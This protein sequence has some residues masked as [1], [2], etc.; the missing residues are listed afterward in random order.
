VRPY[1]V[2]VAGGTGSGKTTVARRIAEAAPTEL[3]RT[4]EHDAYYRDR[5]DLS[6]DERCALNFDHPESLETSLMVQHLATLRRGEAVDVPVYDYAS[7][8]RAD[9]VRRV[10]PAPVIVDEGIL[11]FENAD[12]RAALDLKLF[13][14][15]DADIRVLRRLRRDMEKRGRSFESVREQYYASVRPMHL[16]FVE[17]SKRWADVIIPEGG[18][19]T[20]A[21]D[22]VVSKIRSILAPH[23][24]I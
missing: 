2:G 22:L 10:E 13:V 20:V 11:L 4:I 18:D 24:R 19:N 6:F 23:V 15:T 8:R 14:D 16:L 9:R 3:V 7:H 1:F 5:G 12:L 21:L 17:P